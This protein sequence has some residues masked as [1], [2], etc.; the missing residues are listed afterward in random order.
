MRFTDSNVPWLDA[1]PTVGSVAGHLAARAQVH[2]ELVDWIAVNAF[3]V[4]LFGYK[5]LWLT[6]ILYALFTALSWA[7][8]RSWRGAARA[9]SMRGTERLDAP[10]RIAIVGAESTGKSDARARAGGRAARRVRPAL[11]GRRRSSC[12]NGAT[13][14]A[15]RRAPTSRCGIALRTRSAASTTRPRDADVDVRAVRHHAADGRRL[16]RPAVR[17][18]LARAGGARAASSAWTL[19]LLTV[20]G[21]ALGGRR[22]AARR[23]ARARARGRARARAAGRR[24]AL[25]WSLVSGSGRGARGQRAG[26]AAAAAARA[27]ST[28]RGRRACSAAWQDSLAGPPAPRWVCERCDDPEC[29]HST[30]ARQGER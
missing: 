4:A 27:G 18:P 20:A 30:R 6:V 11:R 29:E 25:A 19:T 21:P 7:G 14:A 9:M 23:P 8:L 28:R 26:R 15:A 24:G 13:S 5:Q 3:S 2:R 1:L 22:P 16:Q 17:R 10:L 12:A